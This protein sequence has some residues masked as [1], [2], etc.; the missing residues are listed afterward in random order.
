MAYFNVPWVHTNTGAVALQ[1]GE[2]ITISSPGTKNVQVGIYAKG[3]KT[4]LI[5]AQSAKGEDTV[6]FVL[7]RADRSIKGESTLKINVVNQ[8]NTS[9]TFEKDFWIIG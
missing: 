5:I 7:K 2:P 6:T 1:E 9:S 8:N 4:P 3:T